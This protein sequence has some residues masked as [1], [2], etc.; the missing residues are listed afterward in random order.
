MERM[1]LEEPSRMVARSMWVAFGGVAL[2]MGGC[3][4]ASTITPDGGGAPPAFDGGDAPLDTVDLGDTNAEGGLHPNPVGDG[5][6]DAADAACSGSP[7]DAG[8]PI[9]TAEV[10]L[11]CY[12]ARTAWPLE[13]FM[14]RP[15]CDT[16]EEVLDCSKVKNRYVYVE[17]YTNCSEVT[18]GYGLVNAVDLRVYDGVTHALVGAQRGGDYPSFLCGVGNRSIGMLRTG[19]V[20]GAECTIAKTEQPCRPPEDAGDAAAND[21]SPEGD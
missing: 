9:P 12:C 19:I 21:A 18:V 11:P 16:Y 6:S 17:T 5:S 2:F 20:R 14:G 1:I 13:A 8:I 10:A 3:G 15:P 4:S 7:F